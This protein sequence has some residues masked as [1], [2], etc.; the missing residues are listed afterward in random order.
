MIADDVTRAVELARETLAAATHLDWQKPAGGL[1]WSCWETVEHMSDDLFGYAAQLGPAH[2]STRTHV[3]FGWQRRREGGPPLTIFVDPAEGPS[4]LVQVFEACGA[5]L[6]AMIDAVPP[7][8]RSFHAYGLS[9]PS[10][11][12][13]MGVVEVLVH[14]YDVA[15]G[16]DLTWSPPANLCTGALRRLFPSVP[17]T[18]EPWLTLLWA[19]GRADLPGLPARTSWRW[20]GTPR[21]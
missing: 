4:G 8:R 15:A 2:P 7:D 20:D 3:P 5:M 18:G 17:S 12:A 9:D 6:A 11:F 21:P 10:G 13:A 19:T 14:M 16:L 1:E